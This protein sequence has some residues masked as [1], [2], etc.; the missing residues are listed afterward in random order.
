MCSKFASF[1]AVLAVLALA[2][3]AYAATW[4]G[5]G[6]GTSWD[7]PANWD[8][9]VPGQFEEV[10]I[11]PPPIQGPIIDTDVECGIV[12]GPIYDANDSN[13]VMSV[14]SGNVKINGMWRFCQGGDKSVTLTISGGSVSCGEWRWSDSSG[15]YGIVN[16]S[17]GSVTCSRLKIGDDGGGELNI[18]EGG[19]VT[20]AGPEIT[21]N[22]TQA[23]TIT[24]DDGTL[25][26][27]GKWDVAGDTSIN[28]DAGTI[29]VGNFNPSGTIWAMDIKDGTL[30]IAGDQ[31]TA[32]QGYVADGLITPWDNLSGSEIHINYDSELNKT[33]VTASTVYTWARFPSP[34]NRAENQCPDAVVLSWTA[35]EGATQ[36]DVYLG[37]DATDVE[38][39]TTSS[40][41][42]YRGRQA[43]TSY[44]AGSLASLQPGLTYYWRIDEVAA[45]VTKGDVWRFSTNDGSAFDPDPADEQ[46]AVPLNATLSW[47]SGCFANSHNVYFG[48]DYND[49]LN[50]TGG[51]AKGNQSEN[52]YSPPTLDYLTTYYWRIEE[53]GT[54][55][56]WPGRVWRFR[57]QSAI[58]DPHMVLWYKLDEEL[59]MAAND[60]SGYEHHGAIVGTQSATWEPNDGRF[61]GALR[62]TAEEVLSVPSDTLAT[63]SDAVTVAL[64][65]NAE[66]GNPDIIG[67]D[68]GDLGADGDYKLTGLVPSAAGELY[69]RAGDDVNDV[70]TWDTGVLGG[71]PGDWHHFAFSKDETADVMKIYF[72]GLPVASKT[73]LSKTLNRVINKS[74][75]SGAYNNE[76]GSNLNGLLDDFRAFDIALSD[77]AVAELFIG[78]DIELAW[79][80]RP[81]NGAVD[82]AREAVLTW[83]PGKYAVQHDLYLG[84]DFD[85]VNDAD[86][87]ASGVYK[88]RL[89][90]N[91]YDPVPDLVLD[92]DYYWRIDEVNDN[93]PNLWKGKVW[94]FKSAN[95]L[96]IDAFESYH[97]DLDD[98]YWFYGGNW[99]DGIDNGTGATLY[100]GIPGDPTHTGNQSLF[101][102]YQN[103]FSYY[104]EAERVINPGER[105]WTEAGVKML[106]LFFYGDP[107]NAAGSTEQMYAGVKD[108]SGTSAKV[109][110]GAHTGEDMSDIQV[111]EWHE[112]N[113]PLTEFTDVTAGNVTNLYI[114]FGESDSTTAGGSGSVYFDDIRLYLPKCM[115]DILK[116]DYDFSNNCIVDIADVGIMA[117]AWLAT[118][119]CLPVT[120]PTANPV[121]WWKLDG[122]AND[123][124][125]YANHGTAEGSFEWITG[126][127]DT[128]AIE[129]TGDGGKV[130]VPNAA[131]LNPTTAVT[132]MAWLNYSQAQAY[133]ARLIA[134]GTDEGNNEAYALQ[135]PSEDQASFFI[136]T[137]P[138]HALESID[139]PENS[140]WHDTWVHVAGS[141]DGNAVKVYVNG[142]LAE[143]RTVGAQTILSDTNSLAIGDAVDV[144]RALIGKVDDVRVYDVA[145][146]DEN[147]AHIAT[148]GTGYVPLQAEV[149]IYDAEAV[150]S[151]AVNFKDLAELMT[152]WLEQK[153]WPQ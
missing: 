72:D 91:T 69:W 51:T 20:V 80:T 42:I 37:T 137:E 90:P 110:Y 125:T 35:G 128:G 106:T 49:V 70:L 59:G 84:T 22:G 26:I 7:D 101:Y 118:D 19:S 98:L 92:T 10:H 143:S 47:T 119:A 144:D 66:P 129:F 153:L 1:I 148:Q 114:M 124:S 104:S 138:N 100:L 9:G 23:V 39:A 54:S 115:P 151:K 40:S 103:Q 79:A 152:A 18:S 44:D 122:N 31:T 75:N 76:N 68:S 97:E 111:A 30:I 12:Y 146:S 55:E 121:G 71:W 85:D 43:S 87:T 78:G 147:V 17:G 53:V 6:D 83:R 34:A 134:K 24:V 123:S 149:N 120:V 2:C 28:L 102:L 77:D 50:G 21:M 136:R 107:L 27:A 57:S 32:I 73:A 105:D 140:L 95:F 13:M 127:I 3:G 63:V 81:F 82:V 135:L 5:D 45:T 15:D 29:E 46:T 139:S 116:P 60:A 132:A 56:T 4:T 142:R 16:V 33:F 141:Y 86:T 89:G 14:V 11:E 8:T 130:L 38:N 113:V 109:A 64:W 117:N 52:T 99:L 74:F 65:F 96:I 108:G 67:F 112:W 36:H 48:T 93:D 88:G 126:H 61:G 41:G 62:F 131:Q 94:K 150:G 58:V 145:L 133:S 25:T